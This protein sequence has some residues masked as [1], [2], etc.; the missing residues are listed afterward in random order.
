MA[1]KST[2]ERTG[3]QDVTV[4]FN[5]AGEVVKVRRSGRVVGEVHRGSSMLMPVQQR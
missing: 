2:G 3:T 5:D 4:F 1:S